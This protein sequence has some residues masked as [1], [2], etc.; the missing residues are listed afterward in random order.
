MYEHT[1]LASFSLAF[2]IG[3]Q[4]S[5]ISDNMIADFIVSLV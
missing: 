1:M 2:I 5:H 4:S 3:L